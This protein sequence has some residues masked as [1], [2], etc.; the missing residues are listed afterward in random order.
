MALILTDSQKVSLSVSPVNAAGNAAPVE[1]GVW[2]S[3]D[4]S[5]VLVSASEIGLAAEVITTGKV[6]N[7]QVRF[8]CDAKIGEGEAPL[9]ATLDVEVV[10][11]QAVN[12]VINAGAPVER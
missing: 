8:A 2:S 12:V 4:E 10:P 1:N 5:V 3:S 9:L 7:A 11:G 6:G